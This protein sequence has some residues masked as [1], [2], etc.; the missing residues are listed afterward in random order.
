MGSS[1]N[2]VS[3]TMVNAIGDLNDT[4]IESTMSVLST[5]NLALSKSLFEN[6]I[7][8]SNKKSSLLYASMWRHIEFVVHKYKWYSILTCCVCS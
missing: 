1:G 2:N 6:T 7:K 5:V 8:L 4:G 3:T